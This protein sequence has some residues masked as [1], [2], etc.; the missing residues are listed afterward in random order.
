MIPLRPRPWL[1]NRRIALVR[2]AIGGAVA[3][4]LCGCVTSEAPVLDGG[5]KPFG[6]VAKFQ[7]YGLR[8]GVAHDPIVMQLRWN[9]ARY[10]VI[11]ADVHEDNALSFHPLDGSE[12]VVQAIDGRPGRPV[13][14]AVL[15]RI[16]EGVYLVNPIDEDDADDATQAKFCASPSVCRVTTP[17]QVMGLARATAAKQH[18]R[19]GLAIRIDDDK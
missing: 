7:V 6:D 1:S 18:Q 19:G 16:A 3:L 4:A 13:D 5:Q 15:R 17:E 14:Y 9:G 12:F 11:A 2:I 8:D 10:T